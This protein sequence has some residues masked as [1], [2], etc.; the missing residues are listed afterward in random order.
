[1]GNV[2]SIMNESLS[3]FNMWTTVGVI[4]TLVGTLTLFWFGLYLIKRSAKNFWTGG[5][6]I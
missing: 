3:F 5:H 4:L 6:S 2:I 1:M